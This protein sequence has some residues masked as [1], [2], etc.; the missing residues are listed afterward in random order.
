MSETREFS[1][2][3]V[4]DAIRAACDHFDLDREKLEIEIIDGGSS[5]IFGLMGVKKARIT[6]RPRNPRGEVEDIIRA[7]VHKLLGSILEEVPAIDVDASSDPVSVTIED[8]KYSGLIIGRDGQ[9][10][11]ALQYMV[12][13]IVA[14]QCPEKIRIQLDTGDYRERQDENLRNVALHLAQRAKESGRPQGTKPLTSYHRRLVHMALQG[15]L[16]VQTKSKGDGPLK[17]V[18]IFPKKSRK[19]KDEM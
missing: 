13:R 15:D 6:A 19:S 12:N 5:G 9:T 10:L 7:V 18:L 1:G 8:E 3:S 16:E 17:R 4:D 14:K 2:K 11:S